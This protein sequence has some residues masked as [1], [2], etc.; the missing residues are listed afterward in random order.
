MKKTLALVL[1][2]TM[3]LGNA[4]A[5]PDVVTFTGDSIQIEVPTRD[6][7][8]VA[9]RISAAR[10]DAEHSGVLFD[11]VLTRRRLL[12]GNESDTGTVCRKTIA[13]C[14]SI[15]RGVVPYWLDVN[16]ILRIGSTTGTVREI[17]LSGRRAFEAFHLCAW[18][19]NGV[20]MPVGGQCYTLVLPLE[21]KVVSLSF[22]LGR[23]VGCQEYE[24]CWRKE[25]KKARWIAGRVN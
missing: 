21:N 14:Q 7:T 8:R 22:L 12:G 1:L 19:Q 13:D 3:G 25:L 9:E 6:Y 2:Q 11:I 10:S 20:S 16:G 5:L 4:S 18:N 15:G 24:R 23:N 17:S